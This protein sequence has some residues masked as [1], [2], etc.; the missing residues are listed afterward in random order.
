MLVFVLM[1][2]I[3]CF[4]AFA[5]SITSHSP[6]GS[7][8]AAL[9]LVAIFNG[10]RL[11]DGAGDVLPFRKTWRPDWRDEMAPPEWR[12][13]LLKARDLAAEWYRTTYM[14]S[15]PE[16]L[17]L[18]FEWGLVAAAGAGWLAFILCLVLPV[19]QVQTVA[20]IVAG[21]ILV[22]YGSWF[23]ADFA[24]KAEPTAE[25]DTA[26]DRLMAQVI[27]LL[28]MPGASGEWAGFDSMGHKLFVGCRMYTGITT[29]P[30]RLLRD[31]LTR[32][33]WVWLATG[34]ALFAGLFFLHQH[35]LSHWAAPI[36]RMLAWSVAVALTYF[37]YLAVQSMRIRHQAVRPWR[38]SPCQFAPL[39]RLV[40]EAA[41][42]RDEGRA[43]PRRPC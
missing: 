32:F 15:L 12:D 29:R 33:G 21:T 13:S 3:S 18:A 19:G 4:G 42:L 41:V 22:F 28:T 34:V 1:F 37:I 23:A 38:Y 39:W 20:A 17:R 36:L 14:P 10:H 7:L 5:S 26:S 2:Y 9:S 40:E 27:D 25:G 31:V 24:M 43:S 16:S 6:A 8:V 11:F 35:G 30:T